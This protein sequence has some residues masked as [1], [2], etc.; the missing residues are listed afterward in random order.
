MQHNTGYIVGFAVTICLVCA[1]FVAGSAVGLRDRQEA[2]IL[3]DRQK[4][5]L[6]VAGTP[7]SPGWSPGPG[8]TMAMAAPYACTVVVSNP[9]SRLVLRH[10]W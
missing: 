7:T 1:L 3:L 8:S 5:V 6:T 2:N 10:S 4:K 9:V